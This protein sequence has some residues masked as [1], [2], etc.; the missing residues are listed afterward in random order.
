MRTY[1]IVGWLVNTDNKDR[2]LIATVRSHELASES[3]VA[4][5][6]RGWYNLEIIVVDE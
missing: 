3:L 1:Q 6:S 2:V 4:A 5:I